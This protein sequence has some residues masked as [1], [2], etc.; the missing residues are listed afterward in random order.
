MRLGDPPTGFAKW[1]LRLLAQKVVELEIAE[2]ISYQTI[3]RTLKKQNEQ[4]EAFGV[5]GNP[6]GCEC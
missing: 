5:L 2:S 6:A 3:R 4:E 1:T